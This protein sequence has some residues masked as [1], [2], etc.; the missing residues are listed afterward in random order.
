[1]FTESGR[2]TEA[3]LIDNISELMKMARETARALAHMR[4]DARW[5][6]VSR[7]FDETRTKLIKLGLQGERGLIL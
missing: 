3:E 7:K 5:L 4:K 6:D 2:Y 1:M